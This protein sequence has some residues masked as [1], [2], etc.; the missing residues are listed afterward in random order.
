MTG[1]GFDFRKSTGSACSAV[2]SRIQCS[3]YKHIAT[4]SHEQ[5]CDSDLKLHPGGSDGLGKVSARDIA[6]KGGHVIIASRNLQKCEDTAEEFKVLPSPCA[7][8]AAACLQPLVS[9]EACCMQAAGVAGKV[10]PMHL[11]L[12]SFK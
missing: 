12:A 8:A 5:H 7:P 4:A 3:V 1:A 6:A 11:D 9:L 10:T 2:Y